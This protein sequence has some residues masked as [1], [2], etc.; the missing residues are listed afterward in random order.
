MQAC[1]VAM[2]AP[3]GLPRGA[4]SKVYWADSTLRGWRAITRW[5]ADGPDGFNRTFVRADGFVFS[6]TI[7]EVPGGGEAGIRSR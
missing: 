1:R 6:N 3:N 5:D 2:V 4:A 7:G